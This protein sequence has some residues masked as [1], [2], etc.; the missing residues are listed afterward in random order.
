MH[1]L[2]KRGV[3]N[4]K[5][6]SLL[7]VDFTPVGLLRD[8]SSSNKMLAHAA[9]SYLGC[10]AHIKKIPIEK[11]QTVIGALAHKAGEIRQGRTDRTQSC[12]VAN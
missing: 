9:L 10:L 1:R 6:K 5:N 7:A 12:K 8:V 11:Q 4:E 3:V 2:I